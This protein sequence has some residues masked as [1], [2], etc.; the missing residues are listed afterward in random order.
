MNLLRDSNQDIAEEGS[1]EEENASEEENNRWT[2]EAIE[3]LIKHTKMFWKDLQDGLRKKKDIWEEIYLGMSSE[4]FMFSSAECNKKFRNMKVRFG[5]I[6][7]QI[8]FLLSPMIVS[9]F[10]IS[11]HV[12]IVRG[13]LGGTTQF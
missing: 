2:P 6:I 5:V 9:S 4:G 10:F 12:G 8:I 11:F 1:D 3:S 13:L 7:I